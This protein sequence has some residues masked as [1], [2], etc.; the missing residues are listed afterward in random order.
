MRTAPHPRPDVTGRLERLL[1]T[2]RSA[3]LGALVAVLGIYLMTAHW[4]TGQVNDGQ[5]A[6]WPA[7]QLVNHGTLDLSGAVGLPELPWFREVEGRIVS[8]RTMG[9]I[10]SGVP[11]AVLALPLGFDPYQVGAVAAAT[12]TG[13]AVAN[14]H[15]VFRQLV[16]AR[17]ALAGA[18]TL[19]LGTPLWTTAAAELWTHGPDAFWVSCALLAL[20]RQRYLLAGLAFAPA[21]MVR[22]HL[23]LAA[24]ACGLTV[25]WTAR[26]LRPAVQVGVPAALAF[27]IIYAWNGWYYGVPSI[28]GAYGGAVS[29]AVAAPSGSASAQLAQDAAGAFLSPATGLLVY[30][31]VIALALVLIPRG[32]RD[33]PSWA[34]GA[35]LGGI[36]YQI[37]QLRLNRYTGGGGFYSNRLVVE[38]VVLSAPIW[39]LGLRRWAAA[40]P[41]LRLEVVTALAA[42]GVSIHAF[43]AFNAYYWRGTLADWDIWYPKVVLDAMGPR[44]YVVAACLALIPVLAVLLVRQHATPIVSVPQQPASPEAVHPA[45]SSAPPVPRP[46]A[47][48][49]TRR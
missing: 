41:R 13:L 35:L 11:F 34:R 10:L 1:L 47:A 12:Y 16:S 4:R 48:A 40:G 22:P 20:T 7:W 42:V 15:L 28:G 45:P 6:I 31:P 43:G 2:D 32:W 36:A 30:S 38:F 23:C 29:R 24:A 8:Y 3:W 33:A 46:G 25:A 49:S 26:N 44:G 21:I 14:M 17:W 27:P 5:A 9:V 19:A 18:L 37:V 39:L